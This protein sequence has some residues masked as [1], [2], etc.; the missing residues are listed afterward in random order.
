MEITHEVLDIQQYE[1]N[2]WRP[3]TVID[4]KPAERWLVRDLP[5]GVNDKPTKEWGWVLEGQ[6][7][8]IPLFPYISNSSNPSVAI[9]FACELAFRIVS[10]L[11][12]NV[13]IKRVHVVVGDPVQEV[14]DIPDAP[15]PLL[16]FW[17]GFGFA[18][19]E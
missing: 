6:H 14:T 2:Q 3:A 11:S 19:R 15:G 18:I 16:R 9:A 8:R 4:R 7:V 17:I 1:A 12:E 10:M 13:K 5:I